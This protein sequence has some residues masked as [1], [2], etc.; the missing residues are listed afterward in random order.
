MM[1]PPPGFARLMK[2]QEKEEKIEVSDDIVLNFSDQLRIGDS[3]GGSSRILQLL[4]QP[5]KLGTITIQPTVNGPNA[6]IKLQWELSSPKPYALEMGLFR[7]SL[8]NHDH[9]IITRKFDY[10]VVM[11][12]LLECG[13]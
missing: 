4:E 12:G 3:R 11:V 10:G 9:P 1:N 7:A 8:Q 13:C 5:P 6:Q 2:E